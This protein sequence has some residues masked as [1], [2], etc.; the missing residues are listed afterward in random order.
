[1]IH[2]HIFLNLQIP[3]LSLKLNVKNIISFKIQRSNL[4]YFRNL[5]VIFN[6]SGR[7]IKSLR[8]GWGGGSSP[9]PLLLLPPLETESLDILENR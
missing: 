1:M 3:Y 8:R 2:V 7:T 4:T 9:P 6:I 5:N